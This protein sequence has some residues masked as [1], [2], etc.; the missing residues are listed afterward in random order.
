MINA[1]G[2]N[3]KGDEMIDSIQLIGPDLYARLRTK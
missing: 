2:M 3:L 1:K